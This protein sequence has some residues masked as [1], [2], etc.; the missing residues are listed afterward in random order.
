LAIC[1]GYSV[2]FPILFSPTF[3]CKS[4]FSPISLRSFFVIFHTLPITSKIHWRLVLYVFQRSW[5]TG[6]CIRYLCFTNVM[7]ARILHS[8]RMFLQRKWFG[9]PAK[10]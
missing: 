3:L 6:F 2:H 8:L 1:F 4:R 7:S 9:I 5:I 10:R